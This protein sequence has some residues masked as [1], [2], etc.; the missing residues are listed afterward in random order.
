MKY[1]TCPQCGLQFLC[2]PE[3]P[4]QCQCAGIYLSNTARAFIAEN[5]P[6]RCLCAKCLRELEE[7]C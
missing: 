2:Q 1:K 6:N 7:S 3:N 4:A 5:Y